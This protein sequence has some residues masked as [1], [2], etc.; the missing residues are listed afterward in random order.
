MSWLRL[1]TDIM[2]DAKILTLSSSHFK[3]WVLC[4]CIAKENGGYLPA[5]RDLAF[6]LRL[7]V[8]VAQ[9]HI[10]ILSQKRAGDDSALLE[11]A[12]KGLQPHNWNGRQY[13]SDD[14]A[15]RVRQYRD[16]VRASGCIVGGYARHH[17]LIFSRDGDAC[18]YCGSTE[19]LCLDH[20][21]PVSMGGD[22]DPSN[23]AVA[24]KLCNSGKAGRTPELAGYQF[25]GKAA[26]EAYSSAVVRLA[27]VMICHRDRNGL[28]HDQIQSTETEAEKTPPPTPPRAKP[29][30]ESVSTKPTP[31]GSFP[32]PQPKPVSLQDEQKRWFE[33][34]FW[35]DYWR[36]EDKAAA[37]KAFRRHA[38]G[39]EKKDRIVSAVQVQGPRYRARDQE[40]QPLAATWL[41]K[42]R[43]EDDPEIFAL[44]PPLAAVPG[45][46]PK[47][48]LEDAFERA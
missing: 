15:S 17:D 28:S 45:T 39:P 27:S 47:S 36:K 23:L 32:E 4:L 20:M 3:T 43:Y 33:E 25:V 22:D 10:D 2:T 31:P 13:L 26:E 6:M 19:K 1:H 24:C 7:R 21:I 35:P 30:R 9:Q 5:I 29:A 40:H 44:T 38:T 34:E 46:R 8:D 12:D 16:K 11:M 42:L 48:K 18:V 37:L 41:N 14:S